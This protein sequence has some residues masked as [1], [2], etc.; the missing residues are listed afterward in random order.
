MVQ[1]GW[2]FSTFRQQPRNS[3]VLTLNVHI[4]TVQVLIGHRYSGRPV[5]KPVLN[6]LNVNKSEGPDL[7]H[8]RTIYEIRHEIAYPLT[9]SLIHI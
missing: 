9:L 3:A 6:K 8:P 1:V 7:I 2:H 4:L 5:T